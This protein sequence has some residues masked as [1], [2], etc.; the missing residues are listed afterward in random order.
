M[1]SVSEVYG[2]I[3][4]GFSCGG[5]EVGNERERITVLLRDLIKTSEVNAEAESSVFL[6]DEKNGGTMQRSCRSNETGTEMFLDEFM[7]GLEF[8][9]G[10]R[11]HW[12]DRRHGSFFQFYLQVVRSVRS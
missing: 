6:F 4:A 3:N 12:S 9:L 10:Q 7:E 8:N 2:G 5:Q 1:I 11:I